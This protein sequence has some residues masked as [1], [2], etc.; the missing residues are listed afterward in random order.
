MSK[1]WPQCWRFYSIKKKQ[2]KNN[3]RKRNPK[4][5]MIVNQAAAKEKEGN[6]KFQFY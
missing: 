2:K 3:K 1:F 5:G 6:M 4:E